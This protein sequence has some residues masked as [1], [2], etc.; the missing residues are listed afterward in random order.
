V[1]REWFRAGVESIAQMADA[2]VAQADA[3]GAKDRETGISRRG[4]AAAR[5]AVPAA[6]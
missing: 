1:A 6:T 5:E 4:A 2:A 3:D